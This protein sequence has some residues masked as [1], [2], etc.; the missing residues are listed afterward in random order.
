MFPNFDFN[1]PTTPEIL[2]PP[3][4]F[5]PPGEL[6]CHSI[7]HNASP[8]AVENSRESVF[9]IVLFACTGK[10]KLAGKR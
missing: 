5:I 6:F 3:G 8:T 2:P 7:S 1:D 9:S 10:P 4:I